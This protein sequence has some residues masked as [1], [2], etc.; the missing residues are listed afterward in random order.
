MAEIQALPA[1][2]AFH[3]F[4]RWLRRRRALRQPTVLASAAIL[5]VVVLCALAPSTIAPYQ[6]DRPQGIPLSAPNATYVFGT[7]QLG[8]DIFS[9]T[10]FGARNSILVG[11]FAVL[12]GTTTGA[13]V[14]ILSGFLH[15]PTDFVLQRVVDSLLT[16]PGFLMALVIAASLG[17]GLFNVSVAI[18]VAI[19]SISVRVWPASTLAVSSSAYA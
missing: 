16:L 9:R 18:A 4:P 17:S 12:L 5:M 15:G 8:R 10:V 3:V 1:R 11:V 2:R 19:L 6:S 13:V 14:G 7:D